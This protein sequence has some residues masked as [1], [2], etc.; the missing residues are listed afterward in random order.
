[1]NFFMEKRKLMQC[2]LFKSC[3]VCT[4]LLLHSVGKYQVRAQIDISAAS[5]HFGFTKKNRHSTIF[6]NFT[7]HLVTSLKPKS[8]HN[9]EFDRV[10]CCSARTNQR[11]RNLRAE[12]CQVVRSHWKIFGPISWAILLKWLSW[13]CNF[14]SEYAF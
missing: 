9:A 4:Y 5:F 8:H 14:K 7:S 13:R 3:L 6:G 10:S 2:T 11:R 12:T 1:M